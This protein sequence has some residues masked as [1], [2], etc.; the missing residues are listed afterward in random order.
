MPAP[1]TLLV[2]G[3]ARIGRADAAVPGRWGGGGNAEP[4]KARDRLGLSKLA[5]VPTGLGGAA[6]VYAVD[7][8]LTPLQ[9]W[10][11][12]R[13][14]PDVRAC[15]DSITRRIATWDWSL[16]VKADPRDRA[17]YDRL[18][19]RATEVEAWLR[20]PNANRETWQELMTRTVT[21]ILLYD[22]GA[23]ELNMKGAKLLELVPWLGSD[24]FPVYDAK[25]ALLHYEQATVQGSSSPVTTLA[26]ERMV[27]FSL[28]RNNRGPLGLPLL[29]TLVNECITVLLSS[30]H[31]MLA[32]DADEIPPGL[33]VLGGVAG[34]AAERA[35]ADLQ[36]MR[37][38]DHKL[39]V[40][41]SPQPGGIVAEWV[42]LRHTPKDLQLLE[43]VDAMRR[44]I[45]RIF[46]VMPVELGVADNTP[47]AHASVQVDVS[48][49]HL[50]QPLLELVQARLNAQV[51]PL[52]L[53]ADAAQVCFEFDR[54]Q[55]LTPEQKLDLA[56]AQ[57]L[58]VRRGII[59]I[60]EARAEQGRLPV[61]G[62]DVPLVDT[63]EG[64]LPLE[65]VAF[66]DPDAAAEP[67]EPAEPA[68]PADPAD[69][70]GG[71]E[72]GEGGPDAD[73]EP[74][75]GTEDAEVEKNRGPW[76]DA[77]LLAGHRR[78][79]AARSGSAWLPSDWPDAEK[80]TGYRVADLRG[81]AAVVGDYGH[82]VAGLY[83]ECS[84]DLQGILAGAF[85]A[86][87]KL[88]IT[89][90]A[91][92]KQAMDDR[93]D[94]LVATW[95]EVT[96]PLYRRAA[97]LGVESA[98]R[99]AGGPVDAEDPD[100]AARAYHAEAMRYLGAPDGLVGELR[101]LCRRVVDRMALGA[102]HR[103]TA[104]RAAPCGC[105]G[106][107]GL[108]ALRDRIDALGA[109]DGADKALSALEVSITAQAHRIDNWSG[110][111]VGLTNS[112][113]VDALNRTTSTRPD[114][115]PVE[116]MAEWVNAGGR[117]CPICVDE[118]RQG[119]RLLSQMSR[120]PGEDTYCTG[121]CRCVLVF[122]TREEVEG[123]VALAFSALA[124]GG[125]DA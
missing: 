21:D 72:G 56:K 25:N 46:G 113:L 50:I 61:A 69:E 1:L 43:V 102:E 12:Y 68:D 109:G 52:L 89:E 13:T 5:G 63:N 122:W 24:W 34:A 120:R 8:H 106:Q 37:G 108:Q 88:D 7:R 125:P 84:A 98:E 23:W 79:L 103:A 119:F 73:A 92:A 112:V 27:Y 9:Y 95:A 96:E 20:V 18:R 64:P 62:G 48:A 101:E 67:A 42:E 55:P 57:D 51:V 38:K 6:E 65:Y 115:K 70:P 54:N 124:P 29:D 118:G 4:P 10:Q 93:L 11:L 58:F 91:R 81:L 26:P 74:D 22:A 36:N 94:G 33:L 75:A 80:F 16:E 17:V 53:G 123:G 49:S 66:R 28:F 117:S 71:G 47:R 114:G 105:G 77:R 99:V 78:R 44:T 2:P 83:Q 39:R 59:T 15:V 85:G 90:A 110:K 87:G 40:V 19:N 31:A 100:A 14:S 104:V 32:V 76:W 82:T 121:N 3:V 35:R 97:R 30:E 45:W 107:C 116:W 86:D 111:L 60:N 41:S